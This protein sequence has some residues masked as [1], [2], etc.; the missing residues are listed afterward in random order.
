MKKYMQQREKGDQK[1]KT[2]V[3]VGLQDDDDGDG[4]EMRLRYGKCNSAQ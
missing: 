3:S 1:V 2:S 4:D